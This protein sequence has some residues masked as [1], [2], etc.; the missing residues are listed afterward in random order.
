MTDD[1]WAD[2]WGRLA[3]FFL[4]GDWVYFHDSAPRRKQEAGS[5][6]Q[7]KWYHGGE[8]QSQRVRGRDSEWVS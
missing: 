1:E 6:E 4:L 5:S 2:D 7:G 8:R 3:F